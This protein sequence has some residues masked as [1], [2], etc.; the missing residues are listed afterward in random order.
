MKET[1]D[2]R[3][4]EQGPVRLKMSMQRGVPW[5]SSCWHHRWRWCWPTALWKVGNKRSLSE[6]RRKSNTKRIL[7][8]ITSEPLKQVSKQNLQETDISAVERH[9]VSVT[10][11]PDPGQKHIN[12]F[13]LSV[14]A[15]S[16]QQHKSMSSDSQTQPMFS[17]T[18]TVK[19]CTDAKH[20]FEKSL[21][22]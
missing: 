3:S 18:T 14:W 22:V 12:K 17:D 16:V 13:S 15:C 6:E 2:P 10:R 21:T 9:R 5:D 20:W 8:P 1:R 19:R 11:S 7:E 4:C